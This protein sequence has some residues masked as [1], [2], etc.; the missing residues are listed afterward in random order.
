MKFNRCYLIVL[1]VLFSVDTVLTQNLVN[2]SPKL[3]KSVLTQA[4]SSNVTY[5]YTDVAG[6]IKTTKIQQSIGQRGVVGLSNTSL[7]AVQQGYLNH[8]KV[9]KVDNTDSEFAA[10]IDVSIYPNT[11]TDFV[12]IKFSKVSVYPI[13]V[14]LF[15]IRGRL[16]LKQEFQASS[17]IS[18]ATDRLQ[19]A[20]SYV[21][22]VSIGSQDFLKKLIKGIN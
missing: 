19:N 15:D 7:S 22:R 4:G 11:F 8:V 20:A 17:L 16:V 13:H 3:I 2:E 1:L 6:T 12:N 21:I 10:T 18:I 14:E 9:F 5:D